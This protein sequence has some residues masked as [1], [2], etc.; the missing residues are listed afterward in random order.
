MSCSIAAVHVARSSKARESALPLQAGQRNG[1][2]LEGLPR[3]LVMLR[4]VADWAKYVA[5]RAD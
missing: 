2:H 1:Q 5:R 3:M 4:P